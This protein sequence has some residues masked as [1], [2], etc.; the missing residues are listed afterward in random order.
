M[1]KRITHSL[2]SLDSKQITNFK[3]L[4]W[5]KKEQLNHIFWT[6]CIIN[7]LILALSSETC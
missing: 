2:L 4:N 6:F 5:Y 7:F 1:S 3:F